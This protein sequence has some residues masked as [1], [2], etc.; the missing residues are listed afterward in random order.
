MYEPKQDTAR[1]VYRGDLDGRYYG[2]SSQDRFD[3]GTWAAKRLLE[4]R[5]RVCRVWYCIARIG[6]D[7]INRDVGR[8][9]LV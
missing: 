5:L 4:T 9:C 2:T 8:H 7:E 3:E 6:F 1:S